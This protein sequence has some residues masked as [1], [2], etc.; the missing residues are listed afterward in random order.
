MATEVLTKPT[1]DVTRAWKDEFYYESLSEEEK[2]SLPA[3]PAGQL[4]I[5]MKPL[6]PLPVACFCI[7]DTT[8]VSTLHYT[9]A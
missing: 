9:L 2:A 8:E 6:A 7:C 5:E 1:L 3:H 4:N